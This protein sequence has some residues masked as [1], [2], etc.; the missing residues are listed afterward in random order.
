MHS[1]IALCPLLCSIYLTLPVEFPQCLH[2][3][4]NSPHFTT[5]KQ[6][7]NKTLKYRTTKELS[8]FNLNIK[9]SFFKH[10]LA[11]LI[12]CKLTPD[13]STH[14]HIGH[15]FCT[16]NDGCS[17]DDARSVQVCFGK[18]RVRQMTGRYKSLQLTNYKTCTNWK[19][20]HMKTIE[21][22]LCNLPIQQVTSAT[23]RST[24]SKLLELSQCL[25]HAILITDKMMSIASEAFARLLPLPLCSAC[26]E[27]TPAVSQRIRLL[28][29]NQ[30]LEK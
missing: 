28:E 27:A 30:I 23:S 17:Q 14:T 18:H 4:Q 26:P 12:H 16:L 1:S 2:C 8:G 9:T 7:R 24:R 25:H 29:S 21:V 11:P 19:T 15:R 5:L 10:R 13:V 6:S 3:C 20:I 22:E